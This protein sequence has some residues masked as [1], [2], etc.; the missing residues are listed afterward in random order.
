MV[1][2]MIILIVGKSG[3]GKDTVAEELEGHGLSSV[4][5]HTTRPRRNSSDRHV[6]VSETEADALWPSA[7]ATTTINGFRYFATRDDILSADIYVI[8]PAGLYELTANMPDTDFMLCYLD[9]DETLRRKMAIERA[10]D[11]E[12]AALTFDS[13]NAEEG[14]VFDVFKQR[15]LAD[16]EGKSPSLPRNIKV[17]AIFENDYRPETIPEIAGDIMRMAGITTGA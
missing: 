8:D 11:K 1:S 5:S 4:I 13:R 7:V 12:Q 14:P 10:D 17:S 16:Q 9:A 2:Q 3:S 6:F 15:M